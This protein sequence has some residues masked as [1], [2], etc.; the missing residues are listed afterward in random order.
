MRKH[1]WSLVFTIPLPL[2]P[3]F[4]ISSLS[5]EIGTSNVFSWLCHCSN[6]GLENATVFVWFPSLLHVLLLLLLLFCY[7]PPWDHMDLLIIF[8]TF[9]FSL[10]LFLFLSFH[11]HFLSSCK[12]HIVCTRHT[13]KKKKEKRK[14]KKR[15]SREMKQVQLSCGAW[16]SD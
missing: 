2:N 7:T 5:L 6:Q 11:F 9:P 13:H 10:S 1:L 4:S 14:E 15:R 8:F 12:H 3:P 16:E